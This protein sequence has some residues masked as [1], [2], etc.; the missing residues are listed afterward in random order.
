MNLRAKVTIGASIVTLLVATSLVATSRLSQQHVE[1]M[2]E[3]A[4]ITGKSVLWNKIVSGQ[5]E[6][7]AA[8]ISSIARD[9]ATRQAVQDGD[10]TALKESASTTF[11]L[12]S[13]SNVITHMQITNLNSEVLYSAPEAF[14]GL[15]GQYLAKQAIKQGKIVKGIERGGNGRLL[16]IVAFPMTTRGQPIGVGIFARDM[17]DA[18]NDFKAN[19]GSEVF[20]ANHGGQA[21]YETSE[22]MLA[23]LH[24]TLP[25]AGKTLLQTV[26]AEAHTLSVAILPI[27]DSKGEAIAHL[28]S[29]SD[30]TEKYASLT[31]TKTIAYSIA[32]IMLIVALGIMSLYMKFLLK[33]L[34]GVVSNLKMLANGDLSIKTTKHSNDEIG[35]LQIAMELTAEQ[36]KAMIQIINN[37]SEQLGSA[38]NDMFGIT[39]ETRS[40]VQEQRSG[41]EQV[42]TAINEMTS[43]VQEVARNAEFAASSASQANTESMNG[44]TIVQETVSAIS[45]LAHEVENIS[46]VI[47][48]VRGDSETIGT[49]LDVIRGIAEQ[50]NLLA[51]NAAIEAARAG[52]QGRGFAVVAD[53][54]RT[55]ASRTQQ[56]TEEIHN[57][58]AKL[59]GGIGQA[60]SVMDGS[61]KRVQLT[62]ET[63]NKA[64]QSLIAITK[65]V[66]SISDMNTQI[67]SAAEEQYCVTEELNKNI[68]EISQTSEISDRATEKTLRASENLGLLVEDLNNAVS[69][70]RL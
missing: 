42:A 19:D 41:I 14:T 13:A 24:L 6:K 46:S 4:T 48:K 37:I 15:S 34:D 60:V 39:Q 2:F 52:E 16:T 55:L 33:P 40:N 22:G 65:A 29:A 49:I 17:T 61:K 43:T 27:I 64:D 69:R 31:R 20:I 30:Y 51:L 70:F 28:V 18:L 7:M 47:D 38:A 66:S 45:E 50:T 32:T 21:E 63:A 36:L 59:Q 44:R 57:M 8:G 25:A 26:S 62:V 23:K 12:L 67:A 54:V 58:I 10:I 35:Q 5:H 68:I 9:K 11:N 3:D 1:D 53:E 56:S